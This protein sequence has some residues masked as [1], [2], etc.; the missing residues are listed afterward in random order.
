MPDRSA[1]DRRQIAF[2]SDGP[3]KGQ[4][5]RDRARRFA[6]RGDR[7][8]PRMDRAAARAHGGAARAPRPESRVLVRTRALPRRG[9][10]RAREPLKPT[11]RDV[12]GSARAGPDITCRCLLDRTLVELTVDLPAAVCRASLRPKRVR[13]NVWNDRVACRAASGV[14]RQPEQLCA[15][16]ENDRRRWSICSSHVWVNVALRHL[17]AGAPTSSTCRAQGSRIAERRDCRYSATTPH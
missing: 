3:V 7:E 11:G 12:S 17:L 5:V 16:H 6:R 14:L 13:E 2:M 4:S 15:R 1:S 10:D 9:A 8:I